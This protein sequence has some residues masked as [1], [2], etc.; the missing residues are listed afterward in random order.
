MKPEYIVIHHS[1]TKDQNVVDWKNIRKYHVN[2]L[3]WEDIGYHY[4]LEFSI[5]EVGEKDG[6]LEYERVFEILVGRMQNEKGAHCRSKGRNHNSLGICFIGNFDISEVPKLQ[7]D[8]G[9]KLVK[10]L[11]E[12]FNIARVNVLGHNEVA[13]DS[14]TCPGKLF[15]MNQFRNEI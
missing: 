15:N 10:S 12:V 14:R 9:I 4:G 6:W 3:G 8:K 7:W 5:N 2:T 11:M 1:L 13:R